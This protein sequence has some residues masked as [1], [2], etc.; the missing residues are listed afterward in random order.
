MLLR[1]IMTHGVSEVPPNTTLR[2]AADRM[3]SLDVGLLPVCDGQK[4][5]GV[6][7]DRDIAIRAV[8]EGFDPN[9]THVTEAMTPEVIYCFDDEDVQKAVE[10]M[11]QRQIRRLLVMDHARHAVGVVSLGDIATRAANDHLSGEAL[12]RISE[13]TNQ[14]MA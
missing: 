13:P 3:R 5:L 12:E 4:F 14:G 2:E 6:L 10:L 11:E 9:T 8:A 1:D 7:T